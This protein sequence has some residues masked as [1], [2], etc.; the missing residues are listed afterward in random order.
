MKP[1]LLKKYL[2]YTY[3]IGLPYIWEMYDHILHNWGSLMNPLRNT[4]IPTLLK[5]FILTCVQR[6]T[7]QWSLFRI[8]AQNVIQR[9]HAYSFIQHYAGLNKESWLFVIWATGFGNPNDE[10]D[11]I[12]SVQKFSMKAIEIY[13]KLL[14]IS[15][16]SGGSLKP[17]LFDYRNLF[18]N[19]LSWVHM[20]HRTGA[21]TRIEEFFF[22]N[23][24]V[25][26]KI[27]D[28]YRRHRCLFIR[29][30]KYVAFAV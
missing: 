7:A 20:L 18:R 30:T 16:T 5:L 28:L 14:V 29:W 27:S 10:W 11:S 25:V 1:Y 15:V 21:N 9:Y 23:V 17:E 26:L 12:R 13:A 2:V 19:H 4:V 22:F 8:R 6:V 3:K 24:S